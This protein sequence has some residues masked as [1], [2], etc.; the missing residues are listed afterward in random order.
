VDSTPVARGIVVIRSHPQVAAGP[1]A[2]TAR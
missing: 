1:C 2:T